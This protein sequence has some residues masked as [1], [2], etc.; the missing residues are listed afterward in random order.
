MKYKQEIIDEAKQAILFAN[1]WYAQQLKD[2]NL[3]CTPQF[4]LTL[5]SILV[6]PKTYKRIYKQF[7]EAALHKFQYVVIYEYHYDS[8]NAFSV[9]HSG[10]HL[11]K[12]LNR[13]RK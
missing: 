1:A 3:K 7:R 6:N 13:L 5:N 2:V 9:L 4:Q 11:Q 8:I 10:Q 12:K